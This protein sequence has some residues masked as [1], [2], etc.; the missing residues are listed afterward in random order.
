MDSRTCYIDTSVVGGC[1]DVEW[2]H[3]SLRLFDLA[4]LG[5][6][7]LTT[8]VVTAREILAAPVRVRDQFLELFDNPAQIFE[9]TDEAE[10]LAQAYLAAA[11]V[12]PKFVDDARHVAIATAQRVTP[13]VSWNFHH[14]V[15]LRRETGFNAVNT[16]RGYPSVR[17]VSPLELI[18]ETDDEDEEL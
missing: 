7:T 3:A 8:S 1:F 5:H 17:I 6:Y 11:V 2:A 16:L 18:H 15:N 4:R 10:T 14:L 9:L 13:I 12:S